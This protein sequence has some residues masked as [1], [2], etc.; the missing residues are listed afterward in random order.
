MI[1][2]YTSRALYL[3]EKEHK[4][5]RV[6]KYITTYVIDGSKEKKRTYSDAEYAGTDHTS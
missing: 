3:C 4:V 5:V 2:V 1:E 6:T